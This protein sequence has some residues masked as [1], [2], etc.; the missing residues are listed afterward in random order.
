VT[1]SNTTK[2]EITTANP[3][4]KI[5][6]TGRVGDYDETI[7]MDKAVAIAMDVDAKGGN[8]IIVTGAGNDT[9]HGGTGNDTIFT[10]DGDDQLFGDGDN[11]KLTGGFGDDLLDG[12]TGDD[13]LDENDQKVP[14]GTTVPQTSSELNT[15]IGGAGNDIIVGSPGK[16]TIEGGSGDDT[17][18]GLANDDTYVFKDGFGTDKLVDYH[19]TH[20]LDFHEATSNLV[21]SMSDTGFTADAGSGNHLVINNLFSIGLVKLGSGSDDFS[22]TYLPLHQVTVTDAGGND[23]YDIDFDA[24]DVDRDPASLVITDNGGATDRIELDVD[25]TGFDIYL[26]PLAVLLNE[27][28]LTFNAGIEQLALTDHADDTTITTAPSGPKLLLIKTGVTITQA[29]DGDIELSARGD[30][31]MQA[32]SLVTTDGD[33][34]IYADVEDVAPDGATITIL[35]TIDSPHVTVHGT[36]KNDAVIVGIVASGSVMTVNAGAGDDT[37]TVGTPAPA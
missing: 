19:G 22:I 34:D 24:A 23:V 13:Y 7:I 26:H 14:P 27:L 30:F 25:S 2:W 31:T 11:D 1:F 3:L 35:G 18:L 20:T 16:D 37:I 33:V 28:D 36:G 29:E 15:L 32:G 4:T 8:D 9:V 10:Y 21:L 5:V 17:I 6:V 12:G